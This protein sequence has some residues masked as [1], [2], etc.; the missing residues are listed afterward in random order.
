MIIGIIALICVSACGFWGTLVNFQK[1]DKVNEKLQEKE[2]FDWLDWHLFKYQRL[3]R[4]YKRLYPDGPLLLQAR[5]LV[6]LMIVC[7]AISAWSF[8]FFAK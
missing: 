2:R 1:M 7:L 3:N 5:I 6:V 4:E 8:G